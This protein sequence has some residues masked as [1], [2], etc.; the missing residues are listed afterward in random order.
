M[1]DPR[2]TRR[3]RPWLWWIVGVLTGFVILV[4]GAVTVVVMHSR[5]TQAIALPVDGQPLATTPPATPKGLTAS[6]S[7]TGI[8]QG[9]SN[10]TI[11][12]VSPT[13]AHPDQ[14]LPAVIVLHGRDGS[15]QAELA[16]GGWDKAVTDD[17][18]VAV[19]PQALGGSWNAGGCCRPATTFGIGDVA[20]LEAIVTDLRR[21]PEIDPARIFMVGD[22]NGG[23]LTYSF[24]CEHAAQLAGA[25]SVTGTDASGCEPNAATPVL[26]VA[27]T[28]DAVVPYNGGTTAASL[29]FAS[30][31][32]E[33]VPASVASVAA[34]EGCAP[35]EEVATDRTVQTK[36]WTGCRNGSRVQLVTI[37]GAPHAWP[38]GSPYD[39]TAEVLRFFG[40][41]T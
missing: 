30:G 23:M 36:R 4:I 28:A 24:L 14:R 25:A 12:F 11:A 16:I 40:I 21:R 8:K 10:R 39:A 27:G 37:A 3:R 9:D 17:H 20:F 6:Y 29:V 38:V 2:P 32:F 7:E 33:P 5:T 1:T 41:T 34:A 22:S 26:H 35:N 13:D 15:G 19:F 31:S 18:F